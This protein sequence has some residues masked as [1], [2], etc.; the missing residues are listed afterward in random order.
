M[1][2]ETRCTR[3]VV[4]WAQPALLMRA[5]VRLGLQGLLLGLLW[6]AYWARLSV[7]KRTQAEVRAYG[8]PRHAGL[9][10]VS[11]AENSW[12]VNFC[13]DDY[14]AIHYFGRH[15]RPTAL[16]MKSLLLLISQQF[17][18]QFQNFLFEF[19]PNLPEVVDVNYLDSYRLV[20]QTHA[21]YLANHVHG[22]HLFA[23]AQILGRTGLTPWSIFVRH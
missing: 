23:P 20:A 8:G 19:S 17:S 2:R 16:H 14:L 3:Y 13:R 22:D 11:F 7:T 15:G 9:T 21:P 4:R 5:V 6:L 1:S 10:F 18:G 12:K